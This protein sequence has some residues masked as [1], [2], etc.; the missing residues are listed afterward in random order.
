MS[1]SN[2]LLTAFASVAVLLAAIGTFGVLSYM[3][4]Q[5]RREIGI[6]MA[7]GAD[8]ATVLRMVLSQGLKLA[9][10]GIV[11]GILFALA[12]N[13]VLQS[14]LFGISPFDVPT[15]AAVVGL[16]SLVSLAG[17]Y[18]PARVATRVDPLIALRDE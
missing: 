1:A 17:C 5:R 9:A 14:L 11:L 8:Q 18:L 13:R 2:A 3:V 12:M 7:L 10:V 16:I 6:C 15:I 4:S